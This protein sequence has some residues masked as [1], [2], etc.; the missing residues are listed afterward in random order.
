VTKRLP[1]KILAPSGF[2]EQLLATVLDYYGLTAEGVKSFGGTMTGS[3]TRGAPVD[4]I[5]G[6]AALVNAPEYAYW[7]DLSQRY[8]LKYLELPKDLRAK[9]VK[10]FYLQDR[11]VPLGLLRGVERRIPTVARTG[12]VVYGRTDM[13]DEFAYTLAKALDEQQDLF[14]WSHMRFS[15]NWRTVGKAFDVP[16]HPGAARYYREKGYITSA[17]GSNGDRR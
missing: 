16:L 10:E 3:Y 17:T 7:Y 5:L 6:F 4:V 8:D 9:L 15:Y 12:T 11:N 2:G 14:Q 1:V 13:P